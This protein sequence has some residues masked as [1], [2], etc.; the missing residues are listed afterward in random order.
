MKI[1]NIKNDDN[2]FTLIELV[3]VIAGLAALMSFS[4]PN[5]LNSIKLNRIEE[6]KALMNGYASDC[7]GKSRVYDGNNL[8]EYLEET[9]PYDLDNERLSTLGYRIDG[10]KNKC[11]NVGVIPLKDDEKDLFAFDFSLN[12]GQILKTG[13]PSDN[14][15]FLNSCKGWA[16]KNCGLSDAQKAE[17]ERL[18]AQAKAKSDC[19]SKFQ[20]W[21]NKP[22]SG[23]FTRWDDDNKSCTRKVWAFEGRVVNSAEGVEQALKNK[24]GKACLDWRASKTNSNAISSNGNPETKSP[25]CGGVQYWFHSGK[26]FTNQ[27]D[28]TEYDNQLRK[29]DCINDRSNKISQKSSGQYTYGPGTKP[30]PC[31]VTVWLCKGTEYT[32]NADYQNSS[33]G[34]VNDDDVGGGGGG[35]DKVLPPCDKVEDICFILP[36]LPICKCR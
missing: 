10:D 4:I 3:V 18:K 31:G 25:E 24:Y 20:T 34:T 6:V 5:F 32:S 29:Q 1:S 11:S 28:W 30:A 12:D 17:F 14:P 27:S 23:E 35:D 33:C 36:N 15:R 19:E 8:V 13:T 21:L 2:G 7:L 22:S 26:E 16:G 9:S